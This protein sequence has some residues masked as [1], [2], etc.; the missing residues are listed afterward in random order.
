LNDAE[1]VRRVRIGDTAAYSHLV[2]HYG[3]A[4]YGLAYH[5][6]Q[7]AEDAR[8][9][10]QEAFIQAYR[11]LDQLREPAKFGSWLR[12]IA[13]NECRMW[14]RQQHPTESLEAAPPSVEQ[15]AQVEA[16]VATQQMLGC[17]SEE[18]R[19]TLTLF[20]LHRYSLQEIAAFLE[21]P[22]TTIKSRLRNARAQLKREMYDMIEDTL[23]PEPLPHEFAAVVMTLLD[24]STI[25]A[26]AFSPDGQTLVS[27]GSDKT[28]KFWNAQTG[29]LQRTLPG[30]GRPI[31][32]V[33]IAP[34][35]K[36]VASGS[37]DR[38]VKLWD[39]QKGELIATLDNQGR[40][41]SLAF[42]PNSQLL[43]TVS[44]RREE[45]D[46]A[47]SFHSKVLL[48]Q[49]E[50]GELLHELEALLWRTPTEKAAS[51]PNAHIEHGELGRMFYSVAFSPN[52][53]ILATSN[54]LESPDG[55]GAEVKLWD[56]ESWQLLNTIT[57]S[58]FWIK[59][60]AFAPDGATLA[61]ACMQSEA[62]GPTQRIS[63]G[64]VR[65][66][67]IQTGELQ[68][69]VTEAAM[70]GVYGVTFSPDGKTLAIGRSKGDGEPILTNDV[71][72]WDIETGKLLQTLPEDHK[73]NSA[74]AF[75]PDGKILARGGAAQVINLLRI[76]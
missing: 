17:L 44:A 31:D 76:R 61:A 46:E 39:V 57:V 24:G 23:K 12:Q 71:R 56:A 47:V 40:A 35:G 19:L 75:S 70:T 5:R 53:H 41:D 33:A 64:E 34:N 1:I 68:R 7:N 21:V 59:T 15:D 43:A 6:L 48:W 28:V 52:G 74:V 22:V 62:K 66:W 10:A 26:L 29:E 30:H 8:D 3:N 9:V 67:N 32:A 55:M 25:G 18:S 58:D 14:Q 69:T 49:V 36:I 27:G 51:V 42:A 38:T 11:H 50:S 54:S 63:A 60:V 2:E 37:R 45:E 16:K 4:I 72:L 20:Y 73:F 65:F 13:V